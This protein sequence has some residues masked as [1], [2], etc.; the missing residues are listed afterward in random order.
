MWQAAVAQHL[1]LGL[2]EDPLAVVGIGP[3][4]CGQAVGHF[5]NQKRDRDEQRK[6]KHINRHGKAH[7]F[8]RRDH[9]SDPH[10]DNAHC[11]VTQMAF[12]T[13]RK[14]HSCRRDCKA[15]E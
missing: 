5:D 9:R 11:D 3:F 6:P 8:L 1:D 12:E 2:H 4:Q 13:S 7:Q 10:H 15:S 14:I